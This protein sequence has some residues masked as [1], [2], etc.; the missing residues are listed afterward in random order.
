[1]STDTKYVP[2]V[3]VCLWEHDFWHDLYLDLNQQ[4]QLCT[5]LTFFINE[6]MSSQLNSSVLKGKQLLQPGY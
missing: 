2:I 3:T 5:I 4:I 6:I 1:M